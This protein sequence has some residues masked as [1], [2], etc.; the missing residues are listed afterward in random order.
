[1]V[2]SS[3][4][5]LVPPKGVVGSYFSRRV[6]H[7]GSC[8]A[9]GISELFSKSSF[10]DISI[11]LAITCECFMLKTARSSSPL[12]RLHHL[13]WLAGTFRGSSA[14]RPFFGCNPFASTEGIWKYSI[15]SAWL[16]DY[17]HV[18]TSSRSLQESHFSNWAAFFRRRLQ[19]FKYCMSCEL[20]E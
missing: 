12:H 14:T 1:M 2:E 20:L 3:S 7:P 19:F 10:C 13:Q 4:Q 9:Q 6:P 8:F 17:W 5:L 11:Y 16:E 15:Y 18:V